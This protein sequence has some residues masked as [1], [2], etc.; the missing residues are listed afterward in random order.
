MQVTG[1]T[2]PVA[3]CSDCGCGIAKL[4]QRK[5]KIKPG[6]LATR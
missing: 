1:P 6:Q 5:K 2:D 4:E 3:G